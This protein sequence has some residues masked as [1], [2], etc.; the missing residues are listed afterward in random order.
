MIKR[1]TSAATILLLFCVPFLCAEDWTSFR[2]ESGTGYTSEKNIPLQFNLATGENVA[3]MA[4]LPLAGASTP[5][6]ADGRVFLHA[7]Q[8]EE[9]RV[10]CFDTKSGEK[11]WEKTPSKTGVP[12]YE[13]AYDNAGPSGVTDGSHYV[14]AFA[15]G[16]AIAYSRD[17]SELWS[18]NLGDASMNTY[19][20]ASSLAI[21]G[22]TV[23]A[24]IDTG[25]GI[26]FYALN[27]ADGKEIW[28][29]TV[30]TYS[31]AS[32]VITTMKDRTLAI[33]AATS[34]DIMALN[35]ANGDV[36]WRADFLD[37]DVAPSPIIVSGK[38]I[39]MFDTSGVYAIDMS[40]RGDLTTDDLAWNRDFLEQKS[41]P[42][43]VSPA[44]D[45]QLV[46]I[47]NQSILSVIEADTGKTVY[48]EKI[49]TPNT[50]ASPT[51]AGDK[52]ILVALD[53]V[54]VVRAG[55]KFEILGQSSVNENID[56]SPV[57]SNGNLYLRSANHLYCLRQGARS[58]DTSLDLKQ[59]S[60]G[61]QNSPAKHS[62]PKETAIASH[63]IP[64]TPTGDWLQF[65]G[66]GRKNF[67]AEKINP[68]DWP[69][70]G[71][72][73]LW[74]AQTGK[75]NGTIIVKD[76]HGYILGSLNLDDVN[77][78][79]KRREVLSCL[80]LKTGQFIWQ[81]EVHAE[82]PIMQ[83]HGNPH[84]TP[85]WYNDRV[86]VHSVQGHI[87]CYNAKDGSTIWH[88][89]PVEDL[90]VGVKKYGVT[91]S[92]LVRD[93]KVFTIAVG[94]DPDAEE[95][96]GVRGKG[97]GVY[98]FDANTGKDLWQQVFD[99]G[100]QTPH[101]SCVWATVDGK[102]TV[103]AHLSEIVVGLDPDTGEV[104]WKL[105]YMEAFP[106]CKGGRVYSS[107]SWPMVMEDG[108]IIDRIW[109]DIP[110]L[111]GTFGR[112]VAFKVKDGKPRV[113]WANDKV[114]PYYLG[115][116][117]WAGYLYGLNSKGKGKGGQWVK[118][119][120]VCMEIATGRIMWQ[121]DEWPIPG[122]NEGVRKWQQTKDPAMTVAGG[123]AI[124]ADLRELV[125]VDCDPNG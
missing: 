80:D 11:L 62:T 3:W 98:A 101:G 53:K 6:V 107:E 75:G 84:A 9:R 27:I 95:T 37:G 45:G 115:L 38:A 10:L 42:E 97:I 33:I 91:N 117:P 4:E 12:P 40:K 35:A 25:Q 34:P 13:D 118:D 63:D 90:N 20:A 31:W 69:E 85:S 68:E 44:S 104:L 26:H 51:I 110:E 39:A 102:P 47:W 86:Y 17:G 82:Y 23:F 21:H 74:S 77:P 22:S 100:G 32:P 14:A 43:T 103:L 55:K 112:V 60:L 41:L 49:E 105:D 113:V 16:D 54:Y 76:D 46:Y 36:I 65:R 87:N 52:L 50:F 18:R 122:I 73:L 19:G 120:I 5:V 114:S 57:V 83:D 78:K 106:E 48:E 109:N 96:H 94:R 64:T 125:V 121:T 124:I 56:A 30:S 61:N 108:L 2:G 8:G 7:A 92:P 79:K 72:P 15:N 93:D 81:K 116:Q 71:P 66:P 70:D 58:G 88:R 67:T 1:A 24:Q 89:N 119:R 59:D 123:Y 99:I 111:T 28:K 29:K